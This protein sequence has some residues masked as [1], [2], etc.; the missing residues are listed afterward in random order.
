[1]F[2]FALTGL[3]E[4]TSTIYSPYM[5]AILGDEPI[6]YWPLNE[7]SGTVAIDYSENGLNGE[8]LGGFTLGQLSPKGGGVLMDGATGIMQVPYNSLLNLTSQFSIELWFKPANLTQSEKYLLGK[9]NNRYELLWEY[10]NNTVEMFASGPDFRTG[11]QIA[12]SDTDWHHIVYTY[13]SSTLKGFLDGGQVFSVAKS[14]SFS[15]DTNPFYI[16]G[17]FDIFFGTYTNLTNGSFAHVALYDKSI[18]DRVSSH[19][20][21]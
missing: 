4:A 1:M 3:I 12:I 10:V 2:P 5:Q 14:L 16:G 13:D 7:T 9:G 21:G 20:S 11:S 17:T 19:Y 6:A 18:A 15:T 8:Y